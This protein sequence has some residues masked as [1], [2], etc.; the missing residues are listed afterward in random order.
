MREE[1]LLPLIPLTACCDPVNVPSSDALSVRNVRLSHL[2]GA[3][4]AR[5][6]AV[7]DLC[8]CNSQLC[9]SSSDDIPASEC[10]LGLAALH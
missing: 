1:H 7:L 2:A 9:P 8:A 5:L 6:G 10:R 4:L 3:G